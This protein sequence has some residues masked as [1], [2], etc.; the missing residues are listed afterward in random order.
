MIAQDTVQS[1]LLSVADTAGSLAWYLGVAVVLTGVAMAS[2]GLVVRQ[3]IRVIGGVFT[4]TF[5]AVVMCVSRVLGG[6]EANSG[7]AAKKTQP[8][9][10][11][12]ASSTPANPAETHRASGGSSVT[13]PWAWIGFVLV[14][15]LIVIL[16]VVLVA[17]ARHRVAAARAA[18]QER[19]KLAARWDVA[20]ADL[21]EGVQQWLAYD[22][23]LRLLLAAPAM[24]DYQCATTTSC[25]NAMSVAENLR[26]M[27]PGKGTAPDAARQQVKEFEAATSQFTRALAQA[28][29]YATG[30]GLRR[31]NR[32]ERRTLG[33]A[34]DALRLAQDGATEGER[35]NAYRL[36]TRLM[37]ELDME[38]PVPAQEAI[39]ARVRQL[40]DA[41]KLSLAKQVSS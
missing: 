17:I 6:N 5:A 32:A 9:P 14:I 8:R 7:Q 29:R 16:G 10:S 4:A 30:A 38:L 2:Y 33:Q 35:R 11:G 25:V 27:R 21:D 13:P 12:G 19:T 39:E 28:V 26:T 24:R 22:K 15:A 31:M 3:P 20:L 1:P 36:V 34:Q 41:P 18:A 37:A 40:I 23:D